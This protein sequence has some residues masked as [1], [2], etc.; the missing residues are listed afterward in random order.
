M[1]DEI[2]DSDLRDLYYT[3]PI[4]KP[5]SNFDASEK[6]GQETRCERMV[7]DWGCSNLSKGYN[8]AYANGGNAPPLL[9]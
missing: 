8:P 3:P 4:M 5:S 1:P 2:I 7:A 9:V 6:E